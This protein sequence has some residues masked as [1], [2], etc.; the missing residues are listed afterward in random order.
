MSEK[1]LVGKLKEV[2]IGDR[3]RIW[4][5]SDEWIYEAMGYVTAL[6]KDIIT[7]SSDHPVN[8]PHADMENS[9]VSNAFGVKRK[10]E[11]GYYLAEFDQ[12]AIQVDKNG[13]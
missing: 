1:G 3:I 4:K 5:G 11:V 7:L 8:R 2:S 13:S 9:F 6:T 10:R 12:Y